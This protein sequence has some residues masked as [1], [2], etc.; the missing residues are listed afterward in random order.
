MRLIY[1]IYTY[2]RYFPPGKIKKYFRF[3][4]D[5]IKESREAK[6]RKIYF[7][8]FAPHRVNIIRESIWAHALRIRGAEVKMISYD[9]F[10][11]A[12]DFIAPGVKKDMKVAYRLV[13]RIYKLIKLPMLHL[14]KYDKDLALSDCS[15][16]TPSEIENLEENGIKLG[17]LVIA[18]TIRYYFCNGPEWDNP[19]FLEQ[20]R[21]FSA[22]ALHLARVFEKMLEEEKPDKL[23]FSHGIYVSWGTLF[24]VARKMGIAVDIYGSSYRKDTLRFYHNS[25]NAP[26]PEGEWEAF[27]E[28]ELNDSQNSELDKYI[29]SRVTQSDDSVSLFDE[30]TN[31]PEKIRNFIAR[32]NECQGKLFCLFTNI[33][34]DAYMF[35]K[36]SATF[37]NMVEWLQENIVFFT[38]QENS[39]LIIKA[40]PSEAYFNVPQKYR[41]SNYTGNLPDNILFIGES[42]NVRPDILY[43]YI[44][45]G[46]IYTSTVSLEMALKGIPVITAGVGGHYS[47]KG[48]TYDPPDREDYFNKIKLFEKGKFTYKP[49]LEMARRYMYFRF[50]REAISNDLIRVEKYVVKDFFFDS[51]EDLL[52]GKNRELDIICSG[53][54]NDSPFINH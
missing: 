11:P 48:F 23:V 2:L 27:R 1:K 3:K 14:S 36:E 34:W 52:P 43:K 44:D 29:S 38:G 24:R 50:F 5:E 45:A 54:L 17:D 4:G 28:I 22:S 53:I 49:D 8:P 37:D 26:F 51:L 20:A 42:E 12:I 39:Y 47:D 35:R 9:L 6:Y 18:S 41:V 19:V 32:A 10:L 46:L 33:S 16:L 7:C 15:S 25:P 21:K 40:H 31:F 30:K 13:D